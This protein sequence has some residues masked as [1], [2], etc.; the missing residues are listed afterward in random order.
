MTAPAIGF[1]DFLASLDAAIAPVTAKTKL[2]ARK[3]TIAKQMKDRKV[4]ER[5]K[6]SLRDELSAISTQIEE[7]R[8]QTKANVA[9]MVYQSCA[10]GQ[11][12]TFFEHLMRRQVTV[13]LTPNSPKVERWQR[14]D[15]LLA[16]FPNEVM[17]RFRSVAHCATCIPLAGFDLANGNVR[18]ADQGNN[19]HIPLAEFIAQINED[20]L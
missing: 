19:I 7:M 14:V 4:S 11:T 3:D 1:D 2:E 17:Y 13:Q 8:W 15:H 16:D 6:A 18:I 5:E 12:H 9:L 10:C 20:K